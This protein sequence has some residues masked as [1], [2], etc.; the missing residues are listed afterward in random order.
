[1]RVILCA[2]LLAAAVSVAAAA[3]AEA[4]AADAVHMRL[5]RDDAAVN[6]AQR[7]FGALSHAPVP[8]V[9]LVKSVPKA[10]GVGGCNTCLDQSKC[11]LGETCC[12]ASGV[13]ACVRASWPPPQFAC[14]TNGV[15]QAVALLIALPPA[16]IAALCVCCGFDS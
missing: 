8:L 7:K 11:C 9:P 10:G 2:T 1:M 16:T 5:V 4:D 3:A 14:V 6:A 12:G 15:A 13:V